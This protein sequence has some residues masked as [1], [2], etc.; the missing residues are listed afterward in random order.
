MA[1]IYNLKSYALSI[2]LLLSGLGA[3]SPGLAGDDSKKIEE[4]NTQWVKAFEQ[5]DFQ[6]IQA[7]MTSDSLLMSPNAPAAEGPEAIVEV[8]K[9]WAEL[10]NVAVNFA[11]NRIEISSSADMAYDYGW[12]TFGFDTENGRVEDKGKYI[13]VWKNVNGAWKVAVDIFNTDLPLPEE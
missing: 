9:S 2:A 4:L 7:L 11:A 1:G 12:Y 13:V 5:R 3:A 10:T 6:A 8:W